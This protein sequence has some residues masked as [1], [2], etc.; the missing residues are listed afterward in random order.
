MA[1]SYADFS[2]VMAILHLAWWGFALVLFMTPLENRF[3]SPYCLLAC[4]PVFVLL[5]KASSNICLRSF[6]VTS[7]VL[8]FLKMWSHVVQTG[9]KLPV[10]LRMT[11]NLGFSCR[12]IK[13]MHHHSWELKS[14]LHVWQ[15]DSSMGY[16]SVKFFWHNLLVYNLPNKSHCPTG[17]RV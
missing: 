12:R 6:V 7:F 5:V 14:G 13:D 9:L 8:F 10:E 4:L 11:L 1:A 2:L 15:A 16:T 3:S 17:E